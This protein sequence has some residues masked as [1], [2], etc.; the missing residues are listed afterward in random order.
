MWERNEVL[1][2]RDAVQKLPP[3]VKNR[4][5]EM[6]Q[7]YSQNPQ[8]ALIAGL[9][10]GSQAEEEKIQENLKAM[11][12]EKD[13]Q[14]VKKKINAIKESF[15]KIQKALNYAHQADVT[16]GE[17]LSVSEGGGEIRYHYLR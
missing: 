10:Q 5:N 16:G 11:E 8:S 6:I 4:I 2:Q 1:R 15:K 9:I 12:K 13:L 7:I 3:L 17:F 14:E